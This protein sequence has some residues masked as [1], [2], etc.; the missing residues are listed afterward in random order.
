MLKKYINII[1]SVWLISVVVCFHATNP[2][3]NPEGHSYGN[4]CCE[5]NTVFDVFSGYFNHT[6][7]PGKHYHKIKT[8]KRFLNNRALDLNIQ[9]PVKQEFFADNICHKLFTFLG[10]E[11]LNKVFLPAHYNTL[12]R[13]T[14]F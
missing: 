10:R 13:F 4:S 3:L 6:E 14:P 9:I 7:A 5:Y 11:W 1:L 8:P 12:F 2:S